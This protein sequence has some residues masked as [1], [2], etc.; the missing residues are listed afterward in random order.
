MQSPNDEG[1]VADGPSAVVPDPEEDE[2]EDYEEMLQISEQV[3][4]EHSAYVPWDPSESVAETLK[5]FAE[6]GDVQVNKIVNLLYL[7]KK[8]GFF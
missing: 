1:D 5:Q 7:G 3:L 8:R 4:Q 2:D 6:N